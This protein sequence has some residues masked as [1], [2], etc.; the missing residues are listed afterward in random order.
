MEIITLAR[1][2]Y[3]AAAIITIK[4]H[5]SISYSNLINLIIAKEG[6]ARK[7]IIILITS[8]QEVQMA[9]LVHFMEGLEVFSRH[10]GRII[11]VIIIIPHQELLYHEILWSLEVLI[12]RNYTGHR[13]LIEVSQKACRRHQQFTSLA[14]EQAVT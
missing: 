7:S 14:L 6:S 1:W 8:Q 3:Q 10:I 5:R 4:R 12:K 9:L 13:H 2:F 11:T